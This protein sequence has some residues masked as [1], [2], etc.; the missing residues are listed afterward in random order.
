[1]RPF[2]TEFSVFQSAGPPVKKSNG[3]EDEAQH[4]EI[5]CSKMSRLYN[6]DGRLKQGVTSFFTLKRF[7]SNIDEDTD[8]LLV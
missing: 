8:T 4:P 5:I 2:Y 1:V 7:G 6:F 3:E